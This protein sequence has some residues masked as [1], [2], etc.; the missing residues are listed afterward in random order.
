[1][2]ALAADGRE[3]LRRLR[4]AHF[5]FIFLDVLLP[6]VGGASI[7]RAIKRR[8]PEAV[9]VLITGYPYHDETLAALEHGPA[10]VLPKPIK[11]ADIEAVLKIVFK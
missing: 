8:D 9:V 2:V 1:M 6:A 7:L 3:A 5:D 4:G 11:L 10:M